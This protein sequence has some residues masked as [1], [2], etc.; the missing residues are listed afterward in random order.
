MSVFLLAGWIAACVSVTIGYWIAG[1][2]W[3]D[4][5]SLRFSV[6]QRTMR[7]SGAIGEIVLISACALMVWT[8]DEA[9]TDITL[10]QL[11]VRYPVWALLLAGWCVLV[12]YGHGLRTALRAEL[13][14]RNQLFFTYLVYGVFSVVFFTGGG[15]AIG[16]IWEQM[17]IDAA[18]FAAAADQVVALARAPV[19]NAEQFSRVLELSNLR[20]DIL[21]N[22]IEGSMNP[23]FALAIG[24][25]SINMLI[26]LT[27][28][29]GLYRTNAAIWTYAVLWTAILLIILSGG[30]LYVSQYNFLIDKLMATL[31]ELQ[32][33]AANLY[34]AVLERYA[35]IYMN[36][37]AER[38]LVAFITRMSNEWAGLAAI[39]GALQWAVAQFAQREAAAS[40]AD[41]H[42]GG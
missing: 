35:E 1:D 8:I 25:F 11:V 32:P 18:A 27:P 21:L 13:A 40:P 4:F 37:S 41:A 16:L 3:K 20:T 30:Y 2:I 23:T 39:F 29:R 12:A 9:C 15:L 17:R 19:A 6:G 31:D 36:L 42:A 38:S 5:H 22:D 7:W 33:I 26:R 28:L 14:Q 24:L 34:S 10:D